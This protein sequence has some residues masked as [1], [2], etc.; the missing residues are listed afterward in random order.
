MFCRAGQGWQYG[1]GLKRATGEQ[2]LMK[3]VKMMKLEGEQAAV[4]L[5]SLNFV[6]SLGEGFGDFLFG[7]I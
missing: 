5:A 2:C 6:S 7:D 1:T 4:V 3:G